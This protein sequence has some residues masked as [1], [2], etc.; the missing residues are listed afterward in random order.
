MR[1]SELSRASG[2]SV[3]SIKYYLR[4]GLLPAGA[5]SSPTQ[6]TYDEGHVHRLRLIR[7]LVDIGGLPI[8]RIRATLAA[9]DDDGAP[10]HHA[11]GAVMHGIDSVPDVEPDVGEVH[12]WLRARE[13][14]IEDGAPAPYRLAELIGTLRT[15]GFGVTLSDLDAVADSAY[16]TAELEVGYARAKP[17]R[18]AAVESMLIGTV[19]FE[20][21][22]A[23][24]RR[25]AL[26]AV[27][28]RP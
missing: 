11:F 20:R 3:A 22:H 8:A 7:A 9:V 25:L 6:A 1:I 15:F 2:V 5:Q 21:V 19:V 28:A 24:I 12:D 16:A 26:E 14:A 17:T 27:S 10:L 18:T 13:W 23:E 4:E